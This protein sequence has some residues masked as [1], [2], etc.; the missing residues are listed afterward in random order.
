MRAIVAGVV[1]GLLAAAGANAQPV[2]VGLGQ[3]VVQPRLD[4][5]V[6][7]G[8]KVTELASPESVKVP[9]IPE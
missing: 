8:W 3:F 6:E 4:L 9:Q 2:P 7:P 1:V 5:R